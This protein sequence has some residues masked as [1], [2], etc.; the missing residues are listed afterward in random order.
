MKKDHDENIEFL[1]RSI[2][3][4]EN[5]GECKS[6]FEDICTIKEVQDMAQRLDA[7]ILLDEGVGYQQITEQ[8]GISTATELPSTDSATGWHSSR[9]T[10][11]ASVGARSKVRVAISAVSLILNIRRHSPSPSSATFRVLK[12][13]FSPSRR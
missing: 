7:A 10:S 4:I 11:A 6:F 1:F 8:V 2:A 12:T 9:L 5:A 3:S 13:V